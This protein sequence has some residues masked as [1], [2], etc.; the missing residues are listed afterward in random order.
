MSHTPPGTDEG[1]AWRQHGDRLVRPGDADHAVNVLAGGPPEWLRVAL[2][3]ALK[4]DVDRYPHDQEAREALAA[5]HG[6]HP[7]E[8]VPTNG[9]CEAL[10][11]LPAALRPRLAVCVHPAFTETEAALR[12]HHVPIERVLRDPDANFALNVN[13]IPDEADLVVLGNPASPD[14][15]LEERATVLALSRPGRTLVVDEAF[16]DLVDGSAHTLIR[17]R[18]D[19]V[20]VI[21]SLTKVLSLPGLRVGY[22]VTTLRL[23]EQFARRATAVVDERSGARRPRGRSKAPHWVQRGRGA[24]SARAT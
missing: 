13:A 1:V 10:W 3:E 7:D 24:G 20:I 23:A 6:R 12:Q 19:D 21:R 2:A 22:A 9:A 8:I 11:L 18:L 14:G 15:T 4:E 5:L 16:M 17:Q